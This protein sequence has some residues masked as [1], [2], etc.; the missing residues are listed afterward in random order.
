M[1]LTRA[2]L[3]GMGLTEEQISAIIDEHTSV[4]S[5]LKD[6]I[7]EY[8][9]DAEKLPDVQ[10][11]LDDLKKDTSASDWEKKYND[12]HSAFEK[13]KEGVAEKEQSAKIRS[14][15]SK[16]LT[17]C[18]VGDKHID[19]ILRVTDFSGM[20]LAEDG[21]LE[22]ADALK[23]NIGTTWSGF[24][25]AK[26]TRGADT[27]T[28]PGDDES[29]GKGGTSRAAEIAARYHDNLYGKVKEN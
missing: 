23:E 7:K 22:G 9:D 21:T 8:K 2:M 16:L 28:P 3:K 20:K 19:A 17:E 25:T 10:K 27:E 24:I 5:A 14:A 11:E 26:D 13:Y 12:E 6:Q 4:T 15:Y 29:G 1:A 18:K